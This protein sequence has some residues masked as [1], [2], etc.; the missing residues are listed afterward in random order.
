MWVIAIGSMK[1]A[2]VG[3]GIVIRL[4][5]QVPTDTGDGSRSLRLQF[6]AS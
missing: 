6:N 4:I 3:Y 5:T 1:I 2:N